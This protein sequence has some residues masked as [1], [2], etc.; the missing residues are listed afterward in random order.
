MSTLERPLRALVVAY[1]FPPHGAI[2]TMRTLRV[3]RQLHSMGWRVTVLTSDPESFSPSTPVDLALLSSVPAGVTVLRSGSLRLWDG[4]TSRLRRLTRGGR[5]DSPS[6]DSSTPSRDAAPSG[7][8]TRG[9]L[10][11]LAASK[12]VIDAALSIPDRE[13]GWLLPALSKGVRAHLLSERPDIIYSSAPPWT[14]QVVA[15]GLRLTLGCPW[16]AD[17]RDP[18]SRAP[19]RGNRYR[20]ALRS[21]AILER[22]VVKRATGIVFVS[23]GNRAEFASYYGKPIADKFKTVPNGCDPA[24]FDKLT[25]PVQPPDA[26][27]VM[28]HAG[29][30]YAGR[31]PVPVF[32]AV[33]RAIASGCLDRRRFRLRFLGSNASATNLPDTC[34]Q[35]GIEDVV[36]FLPR[37]P[38]GEGLQAIVSATS[39]LLLQQ[40]HAVAVPGKVY[41]YL[42]AGRPILALAEGE[43]AQVVRG[44]GIGVS[45]TEED[46][47]TIMDGLLAVV[48]MSQETVPSPPR[49]MYD[50]YVGA[51]EIERLLKHTVTESP[52]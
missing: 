2:G 20:F 42:A 45:V 15:L 18:W 21:A 7:R 31:T 34:R 4:A 16:V 49:E 27:H 38:R 11:A 35:L 10:K 26:P 25:R 6:A 5:G 36:E 8:P 50:G 39:L 33:A 19:F 12:D 37:I 48:Q 28:L 43:T 1:D 23:E 13:V 32:K 51:A 3:V 30:L 44:S 40:G 22:W 24:E 29:S 17:F 46:E 41:E 14:G 52:A 9:P 47:A